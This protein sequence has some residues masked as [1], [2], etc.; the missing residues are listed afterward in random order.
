M[1]LR[2]TILMPMLVPAALLSAC[3][4]KG[5]DV[6]AKAED[7]A[8]A[9]A[10]GDRIMVDPDLASQSQADA[11]LSG[12]GPASAPIP[13]EDNSANAA[14]AARDDAVKL[15]GSAI[16]VAPA[17]S[18]RSDNASG[19]QDAASIA[20]HA[21]AGDKAAGCTAKLAYSAV[22][23]AKLPE[24]FPVYPRG[25]VQEAAGFEGDG[26]ALRVINYRTPVAVSDVIDFYFTRA[27]VSGFDAEHRSE[28]ADDV[29]GGKK[30]A[31]GYAVYA[32]KMADGL[33]EVDL[34][35]NGE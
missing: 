25:H 4:Q 9:L 22:W 30:A 16:R 31:A 10:L 29:L 12:G 13:L 18:R 26:C 21:L 24:A 15:I 6:A 28:G 2:R 1:T 34:V 23:A 35:V 17:I 19:A 33:T 11:A 5:V 14:A 27:R 8:V 7:P 3:G 20:R 32:R